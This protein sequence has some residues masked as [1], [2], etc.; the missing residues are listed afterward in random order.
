MY[1]QEL[2]W[3]KEDDPKSLWTAWFHLYNVLEITKW[4]KKMNNR[5]VVSKS[6]GGD[7]SGREVGVALRGQ[8]DTTGHCG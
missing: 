5:L 2:C 6:S 8:W 1:I 3:G 7:C 4:F